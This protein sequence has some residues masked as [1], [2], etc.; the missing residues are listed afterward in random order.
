M[1]IKKQVMY[2]REMFFELT[3]EEV[4]TPDGKPTGFHREIERKPLTI[5]GLLD[6]KENYDKETANMDRL[7]KDNNGNFFCLSG[8]NHFRIFQV[9]SLSPVF[10]SLSKGLIPAIQ[11]IGWIK[12]IKHTTEM[13]ELR[14]GKVEEK[15]RAIEYEVFDKATE[16]F[17]ILKLEPYSDK[18]ITIGRI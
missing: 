4:L 5:L 16:K 14:P 9:T 7:Q 8:G 11:E 13:E 18:I 6:N 10:E 12:S 17:I 3:S 2:D 15:L 1:A